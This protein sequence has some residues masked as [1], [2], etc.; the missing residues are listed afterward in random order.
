MELFKARSEETVITQP[1]FHGLEKLNSKIHRLRLIT[2]LICT[3][4]FAEDYFNLKP[5]EFKVLTKVF[6]RSLKVFNAELV[7]CSLNLV[8]GVLTLDGDLIASEKRRKLRLGQL[9]DYSEKLQQGITE[10]SRLMEV[11]SDRLKIYFEQNHSRKLFDPDSIVKVGNLISNGKELSQV[12]ES[13]F[14]KPVNKLVSILKD[15]NKNPNS[16]EIQNEL[17]NSIKEIIYSLELFEFDPLRA[18]VLREIKDRT[19]KLKDEINRLSGVLEE[20]QSKER[21]SRNRLGSLGELLKH[22]MVLFSNDK[23]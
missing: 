1:L 22:L 21:D 15:F 19:R 18:E 10:M 14:Y 23:N 2:E 7:N 20:K 17:V 4:D 6:F 9:I 12:Y 3:F 8:E 11:M 13:Y 5:N 16:I